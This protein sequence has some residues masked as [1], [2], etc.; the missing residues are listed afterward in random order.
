[1][2]IVFDDVDNRQITPHEVYKLTDADRSGVAIAADTQGD[3][4]MVRQ[5]RSRSKRRHP[6]VHRIKAV[7]AAHEVRRTLRRAPDTTHLRYTLGPHPH[8]V[9]GID[10]ALRD[11]IVPTTGAQGG[12]AA[13]I[14]DYL[15]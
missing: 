4:A 7:R 10:N 9:H 12:F 8:L 13:S 14:V 11:R 2:A 6:S 5:N 15:Q 1:H 3:Q